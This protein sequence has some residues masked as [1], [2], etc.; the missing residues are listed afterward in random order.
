MMKII[1]GEVYDPTNGINGEVRDIYIKDGRVVEKFE[2]GETIDASGMVVM[3]GGVEFHA[4]VAGSKVNA[5]RKM[6]PEGRPAL[7]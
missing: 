3:P 2:G 6:C 5:G 7:S 1:N 4:H